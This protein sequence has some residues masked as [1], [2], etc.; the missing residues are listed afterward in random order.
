MENSI[1][2]EFDLDFCKVLFE[3]LDPDNLR[4]QF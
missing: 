1:M 4:K 3:E 2:G